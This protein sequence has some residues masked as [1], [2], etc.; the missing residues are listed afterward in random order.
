M[1]VSSS[2][3][4]SADEPEK[5][6]MRKRST[7]G[8]LQTTKKLFG[9]ALFQI[10]FAFT[11]VFCPLVLV[12]TL[13]CLFVTLPDWTVQDPAEEDLNLPSRPLNTSVLL[14]RVLSN[15]VTLT[16][17]FASNIAQFAAAP[18]L[19]LFS[20]LVALELANR[21]QVMDRDVPKL[22]PGDINSVY[23]WLASRSWRAEGSKRANGTRI[24]GA[25]TL[26]SLVLTYAFFS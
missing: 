12:A 2:M 24:A 14:T 9:S 15:H 23:N 17:S 6:T 7:S 26:V 18:F 10:A 25:G 1:E 16:S 19:L 13:L 8:L 22:V 20:F 5:Q 11:T 4:S 3:A 21:H